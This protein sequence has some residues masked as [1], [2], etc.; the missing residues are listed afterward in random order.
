MGFWASFMFSLIS[1]GYFLY[2]TNTLKV[3]FGEVE[4]SIIDAIFWG[5]MVVVWHINMLED[6]RRAR[7][8]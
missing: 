2:Y 7:G 6:S 4:P 8:G 5:V 1:W 3:I